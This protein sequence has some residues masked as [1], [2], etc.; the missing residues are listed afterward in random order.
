MSAASTKAADPTYI[1]GRTQAETQR[2]I[3]QAEL[4]RR[5]THWLLEAA[6]ITAGMKVLDVGSGAGDVALLA[7][8]LVG[9]TG[10]VVGVDVNAAVL[11]TARERVRAA[12]TPNVTFVAGDLRA[13]AL[14]NDFDA[15]V[16]RL[17]L[18]YAGDPAEFLRAA[19]AHVRSGGIIA[20]EEWE[21]AFAHAYARAID[22]RPLWRQLSEWG[23]QVFA[24]SG[25]NVSMGARLPSV[26]RAAGLD[27]PELF[28]AAP[29]GAGPGWPGF[30]LAADSARSLLPL[31]ERYGIATAAEVDAETLADRL[32][33]ETVAAEHIHILL[34]HICAWTRKR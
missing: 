28:M 8:K 15:A 1:M 31:L 30:D 17:V 32:C 7:A 33:A 4:W 10:T 27:D 20:F 34:Q 3:K 25:T 21:Q 19:A 5:V 16:G 22:A 6:G 23:R 13:V 26:F 14:P 12:G 29:A 11:E 18:M 2:L 9:P 24:R